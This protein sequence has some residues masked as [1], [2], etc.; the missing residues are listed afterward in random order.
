[1]GGYSF[2]RRGLEIKENETLRKS[3]LLI[4]CQTDGS[5]KPN[6]PFTCL[7]WI[8]LQEIQM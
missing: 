2:E 4:W 7:G 6:D 8:C 3:I 1:M 5:W